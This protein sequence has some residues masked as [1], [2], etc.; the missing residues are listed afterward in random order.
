MVILVG[1]GA[2]VGAVCRYLLT[3]LGGCC[4]PENRLPQ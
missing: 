3:V 4:G 1:I 2:G